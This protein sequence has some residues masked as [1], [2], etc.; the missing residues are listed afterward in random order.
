MCSKPAEIGAVTGNYSLDCWKNTHSKITEQQS[1]K[2]I[3]SDIFVHHLKSATLHSGLNAFNN[4]S[5][6]WPC[7]AEQKLL[8]F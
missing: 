2:L 3:L 4:L 1:L 8:D 7:G 6:Y 5:L